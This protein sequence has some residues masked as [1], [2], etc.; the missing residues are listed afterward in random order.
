MVRESKSAHSTPT[1]CVRKPNGKWRL[2]HAYNKLNNAT[3]PA[4]TPIPRK[5]VLLNNMAGCELYSALDL[6]DGY[7]QILMRE[8]D[9][10]LTAVSTPSGMLWEWLVIPQGLSNT[11]ATFNRLVK[12]L[13]RPLR[14]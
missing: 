11:P 2:V 9:I 1:F 6:V 14:A 5:D 4:Q 7:Y 13:F 3:V 12:Q 10:P 8:S